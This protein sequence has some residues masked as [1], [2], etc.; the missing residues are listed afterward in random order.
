MFIARVENMGSISVNVDA[1]YLLAEDVASQLLALVNDQTALARLSGPI[2]EGGS[3][4]AGAY[5]QIIIMFHADV[6]RWILLE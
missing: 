6:S 5:Y 2:G 3:E 1:L 4:E